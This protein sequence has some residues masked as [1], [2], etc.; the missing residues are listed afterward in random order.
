MI[1]MNRKKALSLMIALLISVIFCVWSFCFIENIAFAALLSCFMCIFSLFLCDYKGNIVMLAFLICFFVFLMGRPFAYEVIG[2]SGYAVI[3]ASSET[4]NFVYMCLT[5]SLLSIVCGYLLCRFI[6]A[7]VKINNNKKDNEHHGI[8]DT[9]AFGI[10]SKYAAIVFYFLAIIE[11]ISRFFY[12]KSVGYTASYAMDFDYGLPYGLHYFV[13]MAPVALSLFLA[14]LPKKREAF[15]P[16]LLF[17]I[18]NIIFAASGNRFEIVSCLLTVVIY[19]VWR[20]D[21]DKIK[22]ITGKQ[23]LCLV[24]LSP[25]LITVMHYMIYWREGNEVKANID[26]IVSFMHSTGGSSTIIAGTKEHED[27]GVL[28][29]DI[30]YSFGTVLKGL[31]N[32]IFA[33]LIGFNQDDLKSQTAD[34][35]RNGYALSAALAYH[36]APNKYLAGYGM[37]GCYIAELYYDFSLFG[38]IV[39]NAF[40][41]IIIGLIRKLDKNR[42]LHNFLCLYLLILFLRLPR[43]SFDYP[44]AGLFN[45]KNVLIFVVL[46]LMARYLNSKNR[47]SLNMKGIVNDSDEE[48]K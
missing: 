44:L 9:A 29:D 46:V 13:T 35:A 39:G 24:A 1:G 8:L 16:V 31:N 38:V 45:L 30:F 36:Y 43:D 17:I 18:S 2:Y 19:F 27:D 5:V 10:V 20:N 14:T 25:L 15:F 37:G 42:V 26:P 22:W 6:K 40:L 23:I 28:R 21:T 7:C 12:I 48:N 34:Y 33:K 41:G 32:N 4:N 3:H 11:N 47:N